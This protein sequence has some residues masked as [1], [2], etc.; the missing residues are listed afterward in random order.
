MKIRGGVLVGRW[1]FRAEPWSLGVVGR[2]SEEPGAV[3]FGGVC[4]LVVR[5]AA[6]SGR[7]KIIYH[8]LCGILEIRAACCIR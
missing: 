1:Q 2:H 5:R 6:T 3:V 4:M 7:D 8:V